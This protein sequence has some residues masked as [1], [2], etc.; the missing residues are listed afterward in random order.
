MIDIIRKQ[1][2]EVDMETTNIPES[3]STQTEYKGLKQILEKDYEKIGFE[4]YD[5]HYSSIG[6]KRGS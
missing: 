2:N 1:K 4:H 3:H 5:A 6:S